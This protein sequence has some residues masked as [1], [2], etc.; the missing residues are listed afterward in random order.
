MPFLP[1]NQQRQSTE[2][3]NNKT[4]LPVVELDDKLL[5]LSIGLIDLCEIGQVDTLKFLVVKH[6]R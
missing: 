6:P 4:V 5:Y 3:T 2:G 1:P